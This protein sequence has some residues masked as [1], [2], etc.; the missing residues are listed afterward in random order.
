M[1]G[2]TARR[3]AGVCVMRERLLI[4]GV[5][6]ALG[7]SPSRKQQAATTPQVLH[8]PKEE[9]AVSI[10]HTSMRATLNTYR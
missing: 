3:G 6:L 10:L 5:I 8:K 1:S 2:P 4:A 7:P 9:R